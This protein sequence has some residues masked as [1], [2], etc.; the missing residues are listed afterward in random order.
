[1]KYTQDY[2]RDAGGQP[3]QHSDVLGDGE[4]DVG[5]DEV[6]ESGAASPVVWKPAVSLVGCGPGSP[7]WLDSDGRLKI[8][9]SVA[10]SNGAGASRF[11]NKSLLCNDDSWYTIRQSSVANLSLH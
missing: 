6:E 3:A 2:E 5:G 1:M 10:V 7:Q 9:R 8:N 4:F 11:V